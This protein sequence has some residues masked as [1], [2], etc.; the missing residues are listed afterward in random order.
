MR[1]STAFLF[2]LIGIHAGPHDDSSYS[3][4]TACSSIA[5]A[6]DDFVGDTTGM[7]LTTHVTMFRRFFDGLFA[8][9]WMY[10]DARLAQIASRVLR[11][12]DAGRVHARISVEV[13]TETHTIRL[14]LC[15]DDSDHSAANQFRLTGRPGDDPGASVARISAVLQ[16]AGIKNIALDELESRGAHIAALSSGPRDAARLAVPL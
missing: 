1:Q 4:G 14:S 2:Y 16:H 10:Q 11:S 12:A 3:D 15:A 6:I 13:S 9:I 5:T 8:G 7:A